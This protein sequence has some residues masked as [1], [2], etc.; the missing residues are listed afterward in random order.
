MFT[1]PHHLTSRSAFAVGLCLQFLSTANAQNFTT[2]VADL[3]PLSLIGMTSSAGSMVGL[4]QGLKGGFSFGLGVK[5]SYDSNFLLDEN[6]TED[7]WEADLLPQIRY[8]TDPE[9]GAPIAVSADYSPSYRSYLNHSA[10]DGFDQSGGVTMKIEGSKTRITAYAKYSEVAGTDRLIG[11]FVNASILSAGLQASYQV[12]PKTSISSSLTAS[13]SDYS[14]SSVVGSEIYTAQVGGFWAATERFSFGPSIRY[15]MTKS[16]LTGD[17]DA[18][19]LLMQAR[20]QVGERIAVS[21]SLG[22]EATKNS[23]DAGND[24]VKMTGDLT[25]NYTIN[26]LWAWRNSV[27]YVTVPSPTTVNYVVNNLMISS[28]L[29]RQFLKATAG[30]GMELNVSDYTGV[31][32]VTETPLAEDNYSVFLSYHRTI[33]TERLAMDSRV[34]YTVN[35]G[36]TDWDQ[37]LVTLGLNLEF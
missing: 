4:D 19:A 1:P 32:T 29:N 34:R 22:A 8:F 17:R 5:S 36:S 23:R 11:Q 25:A 6:A 30:L 20:Y 13:Q 24:A 37:F 35:N 33:F 16:D 18:W 9:G 27:R 14:S 28:E 31:G 3:Q 21:G 15:S 7:E 12:A 2:L 26:E 10:L